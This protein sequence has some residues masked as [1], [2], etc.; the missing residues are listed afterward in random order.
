MNRS[1]GAPAFETGPARPHG[2]AT[3][4]ESGGN[5]T[6]WQ[7]T[8]LGPESRATRKLAREQPNFRVADQLPSDEAIPGL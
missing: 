7:G 4:S 2:I 8:R 6:D 3:Q 1:A 5:R